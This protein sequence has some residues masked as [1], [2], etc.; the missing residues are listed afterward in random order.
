MHEIPNTDLQKLFDL[1]YSEKNVGKHQRYHVL[2]LRCKGLT[3]S[4]L[5]EIFGLS[6]NTLRCWV[7][8]YVKCKN[9]EHKSRSGRPR[10][11]T[12]EIENDIVRLV[13]ENNPGN[14]GFL[15]SSWDCRE[16]RIWLKQKYDISVGVERIRQI[17]IKTGFS[18]KKVNYKFTKA[19]EEK[20]KQFLED[21]S[22]ICENLTENDELYFFDEMRSKLHPKKGYIWTREK[23]P[24]TETDCSHK[25]L[26]VIS[27]VNA[28]DG[29][30]VSMTNEKFN[31][32]V[33]IDYYKKLLESTPKNI[34]ILQDNHPSHKAKKVQKL[35]EENPR[36]KI[37]SLPEYSP[38]LNPKENFWNYLR[39]KLLNNRLFKTIEEMSQAITN[40]ITSIPQ[41]T[42]KKICSYEYLL[43]PG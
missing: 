27:S 14:E 38:D 11:I 43:N 6:E 29:N 7:Q 13:D 40:F 28:N 25:G 32:S 34:Y 21:F 17:L 15:V 23:K 9:V 37:I 36:I 19:D 22:E 33:L 16:L 12:K 2:W 35:L 1:Y 30:L 31:Q 42:I 39:K 24:F 18:Y 5:V 3:Y 10:T 8:E 41:N 4:Q 26:Y 20:R